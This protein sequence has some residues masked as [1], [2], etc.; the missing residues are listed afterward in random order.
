MRPTSATHLFTPG[1]MADLI[2]FDAE[3]VRFYAGEG[4]RLNRGSARGRAVNLLFGVPS[5]I[6]SRFAAPDRKA[7]LGHW[8]E[9]VVATRGV[10]PARRLKP[11]HRAEAALLR[12]PFLV[13]P[14]AR[15]NA[16]VFR[17]YVRFHSRRRT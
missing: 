17:T 5:E 12:L 6:F 16:L 4:A 7:L 14:L 10:C 15:L 11:V 3:M 1:H 9:A 13:R 8:R 2:R